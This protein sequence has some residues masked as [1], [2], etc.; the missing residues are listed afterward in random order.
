MRNMEKKPRKP[1]NKAPAKGRPIKKQQ[2]LFAD[3]YI[4]L[5]SIEQAALAAGYSP[6]YARTGAC[7]LLENVSVR[8]Y[9]DNRMEEIQKPTIAKA[10]EVLEYLSRVVRNEEKDQFGLDLSIADR[11]KA[12]ELL[13]KRYALFTDKKEVTGAVPV[14][15]VDDMDEGGDGNET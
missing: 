4:Q 9:I 13:G 11:T 6:K 10:E 8:A 12:A 2:M 5:G 1:K 14:V 7:R 3:K 15:I